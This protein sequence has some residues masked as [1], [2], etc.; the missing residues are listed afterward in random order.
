MPFRP[1]TKARRLRLVGAFTATARCM[2]ACAA[3]AV[4]AFMSRACL[5]VRLFS[6]TRSVKQRLARLARAAGQV[7]V[8]ANWPGTGAVAGT[9][10]Y[11]TEAWGTEA[12][13]TEAKGTEAKGNED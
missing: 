9:R 1:I 12:K 5:S 2:D 4:E 3:T 10:A 6:T 7:G 8:G 11:G 13:G